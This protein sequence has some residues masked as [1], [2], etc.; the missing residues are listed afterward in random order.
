MENMLRTS[1]PNS[2]SMTIHA[3][4]II[5]FSQK[6]HISSL[7]EEQTHNS[8]MDAGNIYAKWKMGSLIMFWDTSC[9][10]CKIHFMYESQKCVYYNGMHT[11]HS[12]WHVVKI[13]LPCLLG[14]YAYTCNQTAKG[15]VHVYFKTFSVSAWAREKTIVHTES[16]MTRYK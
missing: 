2:T 5:P 6:Q 9:T 10:N 4:G 8:H 3:Y 7:I 1:A 11:F 15:E 12:H 16:V 13:N 14:L